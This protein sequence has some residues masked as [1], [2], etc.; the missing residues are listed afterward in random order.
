M[1]AMGFRTSG[2]AGVLMIFACGAVLTFG[3]VPPPPPVA[4]VSG[5]DAEAPGVDVLTRGPIHEAFAQPIN[6]GGTK[7]LVRPSPVQKT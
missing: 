1:Q 6:A 5:D 4:S 7:L 2:L 3:Q